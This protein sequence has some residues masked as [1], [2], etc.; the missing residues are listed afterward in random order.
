[1]SNV[2]PWT[3]NGDNDEFATLDA[4][5]LGFNAGSSY[6]ADNLDPS[7]YVFDPTQPWLLQM[8]VTNDDGAAGLS[9]VTF[10]LLDINGRPYQLVIYSQPGNDAG[11][12]VQDSTG[13]I[14]FESSIPA[15]GGA[16]VHQIEIGY[17]GTVAWL[18]VDGD[19]QEGPFAGWPYGGPN[20]TAFAGFVAV[21]AL[22]AGVVPRR[23][24]FGAFQ[25]LPTPEES[26]IMEHTRA[27]LAAQPHQQLAVGNEP[28]RSAVLH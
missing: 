23:L 27:M 22:P 17:D 14:M 15:D 24:Y 3:P 16:H 7:T 8:D 21:P 18:T 4:G 19:R 13:T 28:V 5:G 6:A 9:Q 10:Q 1:L 26:R 2:A 11:V 20:V 12:Y 25:S